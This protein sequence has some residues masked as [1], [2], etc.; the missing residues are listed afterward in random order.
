MKQTIS[1]KA[2]F[3]AQVIN[4]RCPQLCKKPFG[5]L[6]QLRKGTEE[7]KNP[8]ESSIGSFCKFQNESNH[9][10]HNTPHNTTQNKTNHRAKEEN[11]RSKGSKRK[12]TG[13]K[14]KTIGP[15]MKTAGPQMKT[16]GSRTKTIGLKR[17]TILGPNTFLVLGCWASGADRSYQELPRDTSCWRASWSPR[18]AAR[19]CWEPKSTRSLIGMDG[20]QQVR[21]PTV[22]FMASLVGKTSFLTKMRTR[23]N[24]Q[25]FELSPAPKQVRFLCRAKRVENF[26]SPYYFLRR[27]GRVT[28]RY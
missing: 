11:Q 10:Q 27:T 25:N 16:V 5:Q 26:L 18:Q 7:K 8:S 21:T 4:A 12:T 28:L 24:C 22:A 3:Q 23:K 14:R 6:F 17:K 9:E 19:S 20:L 2:A 1:T 13:P 15:K